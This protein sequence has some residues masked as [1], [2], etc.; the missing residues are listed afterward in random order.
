MNDPDTETLFRLFESV[1]ESKDATFSDMKEKM[2]A[3]PEHWPETAFRAF[4]KA[5]YDLEFIRTPIGAVIFAQMADFVLSTMDM[6]DAERTY[7]SYHLQPEMLGSGKFAEPHEVF[8]S[9]KNE[10]EEK[11]DEL[12]TAYQESLHKKGAVTL[13]DEIKQDKL[14]DEIKKLRAKLAKGTTPSSSRTIGR[15]TV[16]RPIRVTP[17]TVDS[18]KL[19]VVLGM[20]FIFILVMVYMEWFAAIFSPGRKFNGDTV[21]AVANGVNNLSSNMQDSLAEGRADNSVDAAMEQGAAV[22]GIVHTA[23]GTIPT[24]STSAFVSIVNG[25]FTAG[26]LAASGSTAAVAAAATAA[27]ARGVANMNN[28]SKHGLKIKGAEA[29]LD[30][31]IPTPGSVCKLQEHKFDLPDIVEDDDFYADYEVG[32]EPESCSFQR[33]EYSSGKE[34]AC[35]FTPG[36]YVAPDIPKDDDFFETY[37]SAHGLVSHGAAEELEKLIPTKEKTCEFKLKEY[38]VPVF[39][40]GEDFYDE[41]TDENVTAIPEPPTACDMK[42]QEYV[43]IPEEE[44]FNVFED[45]V[46]IPE[47]EGFDVYA[48]YVPEHKEEKPVPVGGEDL[49]RA[50]DIVRGTWDDPLAWQASVGML[51]DYEIIERN[52]D[53]EIFLTDQ[54]KMTRGDYIAKLAE[55]E[56]VQFI[57]GQA[58][59]EAAAAGITE[60]DPL[61]DYGVS[62]MTPDESL[63]VDAE[64][65]ETL[66][67]HLD[68]L[69]RPPPDGF[70]AVREKLDPL[71]E[72]GVFY[73]TVDE[74]EDYLFEDPSVGLILLDYLDKN[75]NPPPEGLYAIRVD[76]DDTRRYDTAKD[77]AR[78]MKA[79]GDK[80]LR[81]RR[82]ARKDAWG[83]TI[84]ENRAAERKAAWEQME[85]QRGSECANVD[86]NVEQAVDKDASVEMSPAKKQWGKRKLTQK[87]EKHKSDWE[88]SGKKVLTDAESKCENERNAADE[89]QKRAREARVQWGNKEY[90]RRLNAHKT[91][92]DS[93]ESSRK[94]EEERICSNAKQNAAGNEPAARKLWNQNE[95]TRKKT[96]RQACS[97]A[98][99]AEDSRRNTW[100]ENKRIQINAD[101]EKAREER[102]LSGALDALLVCEKSLLPAAVETPVEPL[103]PQVRSATNLE[104]GVVYMRWE[105]FDAMQDAD[106]KSVT[107]LDDYKDKIGL[108]PPLGHYAVR[109]DFDATRIDE[110]G[111]LVP[112]IADEGLSMRALVDNGIVSSVLMPDGRWVSQRAYDEWLDMG[113]KKIAVK[114]HSG[115]ANAVEEQAWKTYDAARGNLRTNEGRMSADEKKNRERQSGKSVVVST[116]I[117]RDEPTI[118]PVIFLRKAEYADVERFM[119]EPFQWLPDR[120]GVLALLDSAL[121]AGIGQAIPCIWTR[122]HMPD[123]PPIT[124][125]ERAMQVALSIPWLVNVAVVG[126]A[127]LNADTLIKA[128]FN[129]MGIENMAYIVFAQQVFAPTIGGLFALWKWQSRKKDKQITGRARFTDGDYAR[130]WHASGRNPMAAAKLLASTH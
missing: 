51:T 89:K 61:M 88:A 77:R 128:A 12:E 23:L 81:E 16:G 64:R 62:Y 101:L 108:E 73:M 76:F 94:I 116:E 63:E 39:E 33:A 46:P 26:S 120:M 21:E 2:T 49:V 129:W 96:E 78:I 119:M 20:A 109:G 4:G 87:Y 68:Y 80:K 67:D 15:R 90:Q 31:F 18:C 66:A 121:L 113:G 5:F 114:F 52:A 65:F 14:F 107:L 44:G 48:D 127:M 84:L 1:Q 38:V 98:R 19:A 29:I 30:N 28:V 56:P 95:D 100:R 99:N 11:L 110:G 37:D 75:G 22:A 7:V 54:G 17:W 6:G 85:L 43:F 50:P 32:V 24:P 126:K 53:K 97:A 117:L 60:P 72:R 47:E 83:A 122:R 57:S 10:I 86:D 25:T 125:R 58:Q 115:A 92:F 118:W 69:G 106:P 41:Y 70:V 79:W 71:L 8:A 3:D 104:P 124:G 111:F 102:E 74:T 34:E 112:I 42:V 55:K 36:V 93:F 130:A 35:D 59:W 82:K 9:G 103:V 40:I 123:P 91:L 105:A 13:D 45:Y 27:F